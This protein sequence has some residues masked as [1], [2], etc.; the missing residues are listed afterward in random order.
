MPTIVSH[1]VV[2]VAAGIAFVPRDVP[3]HFWWLAIICSIIPDADVVGFYF[4]I[5]YGHFFGHRGFFHSPFFAFLMSLFLLFVFFSDVEIFSKRWLFYLFFFLLLTASHGILDAFTNGGRG[6]ALFSP[7]DN[8]RYFFPWTPITVS[9]IGIS[10]FF[11]R[12]GFEVIKSEILWIWIPSVMM[13]LIAYFVHFLAT[14]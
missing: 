14:R 13:V 7:F 4:R 1:T 11:S 9:P 8:G 3:N 10:G 2:A 5:P 12:W 6:I